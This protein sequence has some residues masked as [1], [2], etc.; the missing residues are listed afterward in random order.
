TATVEELKEMSEARR[1]ARAGTPNKKPVATG[2]A[3]SPTAYAELKTQT[4]RAADAAPPVSS[5]PQPRPATQ[6]NVITAPATYTPPEP[7]TNGYR[8]SPA[9]GWTLEQQDPFVAARQAALA[10]AARIPTA[11][12]DQRRTD[13]QSPSMRLAEVAH[14]LMTAKGQ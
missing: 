5:E 4:L 8:W 14:D 11:A 7:A 2:A 1:R 10:T 12:P 3:A 6:P 9:G 13:V